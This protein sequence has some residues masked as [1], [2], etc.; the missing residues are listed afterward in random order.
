MPFPY[1]WGILVDLEAIEG[2]ASGS[3][4]EEKLQ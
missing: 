1:K 2:L 4:L 3:S